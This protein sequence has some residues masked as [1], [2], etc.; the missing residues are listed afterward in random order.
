MQRW[1]TNSPADT[2][3]DGCVQSRLLAFEGKRLMLRRIF[4]F[5]LL[6]FLLYF[7]ITNPAAF[8]DAINDIANFIRTLFNNVAAAID[9]LFS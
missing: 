7:V 9:A 6:A 3:S 4:V 2:P 8:T 1:G 5:F